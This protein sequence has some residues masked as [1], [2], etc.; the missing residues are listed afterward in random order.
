MRLILC[1]CNGLIDIPDLNFGPDVKIEWYDDLCKQ[2]IKIGSGEKVVIA[3]CSPSLMEDIFPDADAEF[4]NL[5]DHIFLMNHSLTKA[6]DLLRAAIEKTKIGPEIKKKT[7]MIK[8]K[9][10]A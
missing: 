8:W 2:E 1:R 10:A 3:G 6:K 5:K 9:S 7:F 4:V